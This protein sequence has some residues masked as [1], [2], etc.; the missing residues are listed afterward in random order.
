MAFLFRREYNLKTPWESEKTKDIPDI[1]LRKVATMVL[2]LD[3]NKDGNASTKDIVEVA[4]RMIQ[5]AGISGIA[6][7]VL[8]NGFQDMVYAYEAEQKDIW[9]QTWDQQVLNMWSNH[10]KCPAVIEA[11]KTFYRKL[12]Q[13]LDFNSDG[14]ISFSEYIHFWAA[15]DLEPSEARMQF[16]YMDAD[17]DGEITEKE[18]VDAAIDYEHNHTDADTKNRFYG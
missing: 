6:S 2:T 8:I 1:W 4:L 3:V 14:L 5:S 10:A 15:L 7:D 13:A 17:H 9:A 16:D 18:F 12:F 11:N